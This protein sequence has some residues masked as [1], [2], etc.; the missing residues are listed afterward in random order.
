MRRILSITMI[1]CCFAVPLY[2][3]VDQAQEIAE[4][5]E[6]IALLTDR[7]TQIEQSMVVT[8]EVREGVEIEQTAATPSP[9]LIPGSWAEKIRLSGDLRYRHET[10][11]DEVMSVRNRHRIRARA[12]LTADLNENVTVGVGLSTGGTANDSGN[13]TLGSGF[14]RKPIGMDLAYFDWRVS[15]TMNLMGGKMS[16]PFFSAC[17]LPSDL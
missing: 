9:L 8:P 2:A 11:N 6:Q 1:L 3:Q 4:L 10:V 17:R 13:Q 7:L 14:S 5:K 12:N 16:N 15:D